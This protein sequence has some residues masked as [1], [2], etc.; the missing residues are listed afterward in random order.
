MIGAVD[1]FWIPLGARDHVVRVSGY[2]YETIKAFVE[3]RPQS[4][5]YHTALQVDV[6]DGQ[7][8]IESAPIRDDR[9]R[10]GTRAWRRRRGSRRYEMGGTVPA[11][12]IRDPSV[13]RR[14]YP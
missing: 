11:L 7:Y 12:P 4:A 5:L 8:V 13:A 10:S 2:A 14:I 6:P 3:R 1:L 9:G